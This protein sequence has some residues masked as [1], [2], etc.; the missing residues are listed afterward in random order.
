LALSNSLN[1]YTHTQL[2]TYTHTTL[3][4]TIHF[5]VVVTVTGS[6]D[7]ISAKSTVNSVDITF[8]STAAIDKWECRATFENATPSVGVGLLLGSGSSIASGIE[9]KINVPYSSLTLGDGTYRISLYVQ[10]DNI[11][12]GG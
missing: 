11:W 8:S 12:Y 4:G 10:K 5:N 7:I 1:F 9:T 3:A 2:K 6:R